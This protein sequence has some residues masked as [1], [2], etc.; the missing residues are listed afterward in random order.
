MDAKEKAEITKTIEL[1]EKL[2]KESPAVIKGEEKKASLI[3]EIL[4]QKNLRFKEQIYN[5]VKPEFKEF[6][7]EI[8]GEKIECLPSGLKS[9]KIT[10]KNIID[11]LS[12][13]GSKY[14][15]PNINFNPYCNRVSKPT[16][17]D[18][19]ALSVSKEDIPEI[20]DAET[21]EGKLEIE[22][23]KHT[24]KNFLLGNTENPEAVVF[25][26]YDSWW[27]GFIDNS[28]SVAALLQVTE[29]LDLD[30][31]TVVIAGSEEISHQNTYQGYGYKMFEKEYFQSLKSAEEIIVVDCIGKG[32]TTVK[33]GEYLYEETL[34]LNHDFQDKFKLLEGDWNEIKKIYHSPEDTEKAL[35][36]PEQAV[37]KVKAVL[38]P[39]LEN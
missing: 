18:A 24:S 29:K 31:I 3:E 37:E 33:S 34:A 36:N 16:F 32:K 21:V 39:W 8:D 35:T 23:I 30:K 25:T 13:P 2:S 6:W 26:H 7:L 15:E 4:S 10:E 38:Q 9:G 5:V 14:S 11:S 20:L 27:G 12:I 1:A 19:P 22:W 28:L 17:Y